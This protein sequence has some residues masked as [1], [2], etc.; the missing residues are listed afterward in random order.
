MVPTV[1]RGFFEVD[2]WSIET[3][4]RQALDEVDVGLVHLA[5]ELAGVRRQR[6][7]VAPLALGEDRVER[8]RGLARAGQPGEDDQRVAGQ[9]DRDVLE[10]VLPGP[11]DDELIRHC[12]PLV[13]EQVFA[14]LTGARP[15]T[16][17][18]ARRCSPRSHAPPTVLGARPVRQDVTH[19]RADSQPSETSCPRRPGAWSG[20]PTR[21][22]DEAYA[23]PSG[24]PGWTRGARRW[25][26]SRSTPRGWPARSPASSR[27]SGCRCT[28]PRRR[29]TATSTSSP[30]AGPVRDPRPAARRDA[31][32]C[33]DAIAAVPDDRWDT[34]IERSPGGRTFAAGDGAR[35][36][37]A[38]GRDPPRRPGGRLHARRLAAGV[39]RR[40]CWT[41]LTSKGVSADA[42]PAR[43]TDLDRHVDVRRG[44]PDRE[45]HRPPTSAG[46]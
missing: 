42:V 46:G 5:E 21:L 28:P 11:P 16:T 24:L 35:D 34:T 31:P 14:I 37:A 38:R 20:P 8:Q 4:G 36:A 17:T 13:F 1:E 39:R 33:R 44:R 18:R 25:P 40:C 29:G 15:G 9:V 7:D 41:A 43:A 10:V 32:S 19:A 6:L 30:R 2:F 12:V 23:E 22:A 45:R 27:A 26:T 3:A